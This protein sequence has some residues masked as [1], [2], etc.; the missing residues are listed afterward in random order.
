MFEEI[1]DSLGEKDMVARWPYHLAL[2]TY[3]NTYIHKYLHILV[4]TYNIY[5]IIYILYTHITV[6][7]YSVSFKPESQHD[8][9]QSSNAKLSEIAKLLSWAAKHCSAQSG[10]G[11][12]QPWG[13]ITSIQKLNFHQQTAPRDAMTLGILQG[14]P[15]IALSDRVKIQGAARHGSSFIE[16][17][18]LCGNSWTLEGLI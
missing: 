9:R 1:G 8:P 6:H 11:T 4:C 7:I 2:H 16:D 3:S 17:L 10:A 18:S 15:T 14:Q 5:I 13:N 12:L